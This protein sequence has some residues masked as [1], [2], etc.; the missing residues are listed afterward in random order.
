MVVLGIKSGVFR[1]LIKLIS[2]K[3]TK[4]SWEMILF[5]FFKLIS[6]YLKSKKRDLWH[7]KSLYFLMN[8]TNL[9]NLI[10][11]KI[12][13]SFL[14]MSYTIRFVQRNDLRKNILESLLQNPIEKSLKKHMILYRVRIF[15]ICKFKIFTRSCLFSKKFLVFL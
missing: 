15:R 13:I 6:K 2:L 9:H 1:Y 5:L 4:W 11:S 7:F 8:F 12:L 3:I 10:L 14:Y